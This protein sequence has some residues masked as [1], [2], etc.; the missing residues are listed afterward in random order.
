MRVEAFERV[1]DGVVAAH[2]LAFGT[3]F[4]AVVYAK[5]RVDVRRG[6]V[7]EMADQLSGAHAT[8]DG[9]AGGVVGAA[10]DSK[11]P[12]DAVED[13]G[14]LGCGL[15]DGAGGDGEH[16]SELGAVAEPVELCDRVRGA[17]EH[18]LPVA[19]ARLATR[20]AWVV[21]RTFR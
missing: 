20:T 9:R 11:P 1:R 8:L 7:P 2:G 4:Q 19:Y 12:G 15:D 10:R 13:G 5:H 3:Q 14:G 6:L 18:D 17:L 16:S 21:S